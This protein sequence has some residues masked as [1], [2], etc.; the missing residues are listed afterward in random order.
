MAAGF[1][2]PIDIHRREACRASKKKSAL[3]ARHRR[4]CPVRGVPVLA[5]CPGSDDQLELRLHGLGLEQLDRHDQHVDGAFDRHV[6]HHGVWRPGRACVERRQ[7]LRRRAGCC[8]WRQ[9]S[10][11]LRRHPDHPGWC[12]GHVEQLR[13][14]R[15]R[16]KFCGH[17]LHRSLG[18]GWRR[19]RRR[20][21]KQR[22]RR[23]HNHV[24]QQ[25]SVLSNECAGV[26]RDQ[27]KRRFHRKQFGLAWRRRRGRIQRQRR[28]ALS[29]LRL[30]PRPTGRARW[31]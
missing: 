4:W 6:C 7:Y 21:S 20:R 9:L 26:R 11:Q 25:C 3:E 30:R 23:E 27:R 14:L 10:H 16:G 13:R 8:D 31:F 12:R 28:N 1:S 5:T 2:R 17:V 15:R 24:R 29:N 19:R 18:G 22:N